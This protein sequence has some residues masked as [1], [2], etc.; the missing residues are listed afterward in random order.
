[1]NKHLVGIAAIVAAAPVLF[2]GGGPKRPDKPFP[3]AESVDAALEEA[4]DRNVPV[5]V[6]LG[7]DH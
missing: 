7:K 2:A 3:W 4:A 5:L 6:S 1:M